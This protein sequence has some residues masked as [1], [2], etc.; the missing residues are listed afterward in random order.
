MA[1]ILAID[2]GTKRIGLAIADEKLKIPLPLKPIIEKN[3]QQVLEKIANLCKE[4]NVFQIVIGLPLSFNFEET[5]MCQEI[6]VF[7][8]K[9]KQITGTKIIYENEVLTTEAAKKLRQTAL[10]L[11]SREDSSKNHFDSQAASLILESYLKKV[12]S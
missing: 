12:K 5:P 10:R 6:R 1:N 7:G 2:Y 8:E 4:K 3:Q 9:L 11:K